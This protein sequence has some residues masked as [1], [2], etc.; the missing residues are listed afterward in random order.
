MLKFHRK[1]KVIGCGPY[2]VSGGGQL[3]TLGRIT[4]K[5][6]VTCNGETPFVIIVYFPLCVLAKNVPDDGCNY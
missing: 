5:Y 4:H 2:C 6:N 1:T 3:A